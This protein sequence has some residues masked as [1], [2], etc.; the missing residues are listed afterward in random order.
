M[1]LY[2]ADYLADTAHLTAMQHGI[3]LLL[4]MNYWQRGGPLPNDDIRLARIARVS[5][6]DWKRNRPELEQFFTV[7][8]SHW[9]HLRVDTELNLVSAKSLK[10]KAAAQASVERRFG[11]RST[12]VEP[13][14]TEADTT[15]T[16]VVVPRKA[17]RSP[18][19]PISHD[20]LPEPF[21][22][23]TEC[24]RIME[25]WGPK[26]HAEEVE[27]FKAHHGS[28]AN[29]MADWQKAWQTWVLNSKKFDRS[30]GNGK[31]PTGDRTLAGAEAAFGPY[32]SWTDD[33]PF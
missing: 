32:A 25:D 33:K 22:T 23:E 27:A 8:E 12:S 29:V 20:W 4:I 28:R 19:K 11:E 21:R 18:K 26:R 15:T 16:S 30:R 5:M 17:R 14:D 9:R 6:R 13:T 10:S 31:Q 1:R 3:Y 2:P 24:Q 7:E